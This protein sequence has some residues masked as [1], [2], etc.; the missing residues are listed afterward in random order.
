MQRSS[1]LFKLK[2]KNKNKK[3]ELLFYLNMYSFLRLHWI[4]GM[5]Y[6]LLVAACGI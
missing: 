2:K 1:V 5:A 3:P 6:E 4:L